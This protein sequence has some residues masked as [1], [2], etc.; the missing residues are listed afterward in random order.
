MAPTTLEIELRN[1]SSSPTVFAYITGREINHNNDWVL[2]EADGSTLYHPTSPSDILQPLTRD[3]GIRL[4]PPG[5]S[6]RVTIPQIAGG[7]IWF[8]IDKPLTFLLNPGPAL[9]EPSVTNPSDL[10]YNTTWH[11]CEFTFNATQ[12]FANISYVDFVCL[13]ISLTLTNS[14]NGMQHVAGHGPNGLAQV[15]QGLEAQHAKDGAGWD[16]LIVRQNGQVLRALSPNNGLVLNPALFEDYWRSY[17]DESWARYV[18]RNLTI[19]TQAGAGLVQGKV[20]NDQI[21][22][23]Q[24]CF[25]KPTSRDVFGCS[26]GPF[27]PTGSPDVLAIIPRLAAAINRSTLHSFDFQPD[28]NAVDKYYGNAVTNHYARIVHEVNLDGRGYAFPYDDVVPGG[29]QDVAG[30][31]FDGDPV[32]FTVSVGGQ[33]AHK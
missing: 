32:L 6:R 30:T 16:S 3:C 9:V 26:S 15:V 17:V 28:I 27:T 1:Q 14:R 31:L 2:L 12:L 13:P 10:N 29:G 19:D 22:F 24:G 33:D 20:K 7:R 25:A 21:C 23:P 8:S 11:F 5:S 4:G 18:D